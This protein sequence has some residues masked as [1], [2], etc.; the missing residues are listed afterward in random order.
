MFNTRNTNILWLLIMVACYSMPIQGEQNMATV[1]FSEQ[2]ADN[3][4]AA[5]GWK[6]SWTSVANNTTIFN[7]PERGFDATLGKNY[8]AIKYNATMSE[9]HG[10]GDVDYH[11]FSTPQDEITSVVFVN[12]ISWDFAKPNHTFGLYSNQETLPNLVPPM[13]K[14][15]VDILLPASTGVKTISPGF[16]NRG[17]TG[18]AFNY[19]PPGVGAVVG[20]VFT[21]GVWYELRVRAKLNTPGTANGILMG[22]ARKVGDTAWITTFN[23]TDAKFIVAAGVSNI[24]FMHPAFRMHR[25]PPGAAPGD[26]IRVAD[27]KIY[28]GNQIGVD[29][30]GT[31]PVPVPPDTVTK[32]EFD[33]LALKVTALETR[34]SS[35]ETKGG[36][37]EMR[38]TSL[39]ADG[40]A[41]GSRV[42]GIKTEVD[43]LVDKTAR[44]KAI[45]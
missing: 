2:F 14:L 22:Q 43:V 36:A 45:L 1:L 15:D 44:V 3:N 5:R 11:A 39:E 32:V 41:L 33:A 10:M 24:K 19:P 34:V 18:G 30:G 20:N 23:R 4:F 37:L 25:Q 26:E 12:F 17:Q 29:L 42:T 35:L 6:S 7:P 21:T 28:Q 40:I 13:A 27:W 38:V 31:P 8:V 16:V 9:P